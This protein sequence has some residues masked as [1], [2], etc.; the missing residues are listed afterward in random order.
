MEM[1]IVVA[2]FS[3]ASVILSQTYVSFNQL[4]RKVANAAILGQDMRFA[5]ELIVRAARNNRI[6]FTGQPLP[7]RDNRL[8][9]LTSTGGT[10]D[11]AAR[12]GAA[13]CQDTTVTTCLAMSL[14]GGTTWQPITARRVNVTNFDVYVRPS[15]SPFIP[16]GGGYDNDTQPFV[17]VNIGLQYMAPNPKDQVRLR[18]QTTV[19]SRVY[20]R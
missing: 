16:T 3:A 17:T 13:D 2:L 9:L 4:H 12:T 14:D 6:D 15:N 7:A 1:L 10:I 19:A 5:T 20:V 11:I 18:A 8:R